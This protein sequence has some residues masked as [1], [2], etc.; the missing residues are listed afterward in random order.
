M[1]SDDQRKTSTGSTVEANFAEAVGHLG[2]ALLSSLQV[3]EGALRQ[4]HPPRI[5]ALRESLRPV[6]PRLEL[7]RVALQSAAAPAELE[8]F[9]ESL[10]RSAQHAE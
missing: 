2:P 7:R 5:E 6:L 10:G 3:M 8:A 4:M 1:A 9:S